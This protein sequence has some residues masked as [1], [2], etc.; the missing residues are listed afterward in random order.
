[1]LP[2][3]PFWPA[4]LRHATAAAVIPRQEVVVEVLPSA[5]G[6]EVNSQVVEEEALPWAWEV[7]VTPWAWAVEASCQEQP[8]VDALLLL[9]S[10]VA[11]PAAAPVPFLPVPVAEC[12]PDWT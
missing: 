5:W 3:W 8:V 10:F 6:E 9:L 4:E 2:S 7:A 1:M 11:T 12:D